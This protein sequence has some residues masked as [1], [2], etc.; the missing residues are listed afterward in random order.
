MF[1]GDTYAKARL[2]A[3]LF[4]KSLSTPAAAMDS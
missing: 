2:K 1:G 3:A 4:G